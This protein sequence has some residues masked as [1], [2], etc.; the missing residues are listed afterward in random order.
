MAEQPPPI[1]EPQTLRLLSFNMQVGIGTRRYHEYL[2]RGWRHLLPSLQ[3]RN[4]LTNIAEL[5]AGY[6]IVGLQE[7]DAGSRRSR[8]RDQTETLAEQAHFPHWYSQVNRDFGQVAQHGLGF[9]SR[10]QPRVVTEHK[11]PG[12][13]PGRGAILAEFGHPKTTFA[14]VVTHLALMRRSRTDQLAAISE[15]VAPFP[16]AVIMGDINCDTERLRKNEAFTDGNLRIHDP[17]QPT[18]PSWRPRRTLDHIMTTPGLGVVDSRSLD[19]HLSD[20]LPVALRLTVPQEVSQ[21][22][23]FTSRE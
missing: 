4:N 8:Y 7:I 18:F 11:L 5:I 6:D 13:L 21:S 17:D 23:G 20:H 1:S 3:V 9:L 10:Y 12:L 19:I 2:T 16:H 22:C 14:V 15:L